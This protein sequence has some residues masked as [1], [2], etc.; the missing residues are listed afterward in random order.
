MGR[1]EDSNGGV[2]D[3][4]GPVAAAHR[5][6]G[7]TS[8]LRRVVAVNA[9]VLVGACAVT[10]AV[11]AP[12]DFDASAAEE[13]I[14]LAGASAIM[15]VLNVVL[16][17]AALAPLAQ[18]TR[19]AQTLDPGRTGQRVQVSGPPSEATELGHALNDTLARVEHERREATR[20][21]LAAQEAERL[22]VAQELHDE[23]G[24]S[25]TAVLLQL[26]R[27]AR[28]APREL[29]AQLAE[30]QETARQ[31]LD[32]VRRIA[33]E[34]RPEALDDLGL[35]SALAG[36]LDAGMAVRVRCSIEGDLPHLSEEQ[37]L[38]IY[39]VAQEA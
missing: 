6:P 19:L 38:V 31:S 29:A 1:V 27:T 14:V 32:D 8:L 30:T 12:R 17:R 3:P 15:L 7:Y 5:I 26:A 23:V 22:R 37:E 20:R 18:L 34:L 36:R 24:Q 10:L 9:G 2:R 13:A 25:L 21:V 4:P 11:F 39:R 28:L 35:P 33:R 16:L